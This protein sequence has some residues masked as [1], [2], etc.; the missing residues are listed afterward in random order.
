MIYVITFDPHK[1]D[2]N[3]LHSIIDQSRLFLSW[4]HYVGSTYLV[5][6]EFSSSDITDEIIKKWPKNR[7]FVAEIDPYNYN[8]WL[9]PKAWEW[10]KKHRN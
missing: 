6:S 8:G 3:Q 2:A 5:K 4:W 7:F 1:V 9:P 10:I